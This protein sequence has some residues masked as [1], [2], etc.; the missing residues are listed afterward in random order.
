VDDGYDLDLIVQIGLVSGHTIDEEVEIDGYEVRVV[1]H[2]RFDLDH[3]IVLAAFYDGVLLVH[4]HLYTVGSCRRR[5]P[6][7]AGN[8]LLTDGDVGH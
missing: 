3:I 6:S 2:I 5:G 4:D 7:D 1:G 8:A